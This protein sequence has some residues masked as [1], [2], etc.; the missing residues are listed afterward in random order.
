MS[1]LKVTNIE[2]A[3]GTSGITLA[4]STGKATFAGGSN[5]VEHVTGLTVS[6]TTVTEF[7]TNLTGSALNGGAKSLTIFLSD[8]NNPGNNYMHF[9]I[10]SSDGYTDNGYGA[11]F[12]YTTGNTHYQ[13][14][15]TDA[16]QNAKMAFTYYAGNYN[17]RIDCLLVDPSNNHWVFQGDAMNF[18][19][20][21][22]TSGGSLAHNI[23]GAG[24][25][26][27]G[28]KFSSGGA[29]G[30]NVSNLKYGYKYTT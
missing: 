28:F 30:L 6:G 19:T 11:S 29:N 21:P 9:S 20:N 13:N 16:N 1:T 10:K 24:K 7:E 15:Y 12:R 2:A 14:N 4:N 25:P 22:A 5:L 8:L 3:D 17:V 26:I 23:L 27:T 18:A